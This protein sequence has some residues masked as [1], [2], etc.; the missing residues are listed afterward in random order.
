MSDTRNVFKLKIEMGN[1]AMM[2]R[3]HIAGAL[4]RIADT[5]GARL[6]NGAIEGII[7]DYN[8]NTVGQWEFCAEEET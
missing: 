1:A 3:G 5:V 4:R 6:G 2:R 8:G 7:R